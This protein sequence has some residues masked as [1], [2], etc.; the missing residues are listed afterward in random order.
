LVQDQAILD[1]LTG[2]AEPSA[3]LPL[4]MPKDMLTVEKQFEDVPHDM[5]VYKDSE[6][7]SYDFGFG[8]NWKGAIK[9]ARTAKYLSAK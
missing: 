6:G 4:Q 3:L 2:A 1:V 5:E 7:N 9:D 8:L